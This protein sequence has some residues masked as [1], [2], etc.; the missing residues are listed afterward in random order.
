MRDHGYTEQQIDAGGLRITTTVNK[1]Y[2][3]AAVASGQRRDGRART[4][5]TLREALV[6]DRPEDRRGASPTTAGRAAPTYDYAQAQRQPGSSMKPYVLATALEQGIGVQARRDGSSPQTFPDRDGRRSCNS[7]GASCPACTLQEAITR[8]LNTTFYGLAYE[9]GPGERPR[10][11]A[12][13]HRPARDLGDR[14]QPGRQARRWPTRRAAAPARR[15][16]S[17]STR[18]ARSTRR[19]G[20]P[21]SPAGGVH[22]DPYFVAKVDRLRGHRAARTRRRRGRAGDPGRR[23]Q[24]RHLR[25]SRA[26]PQYSRRALDGGREVASKTGTAGPRPGEQLRRLDGR[27][28][29]VDLDGGLDG[30]RRPSSRSSTPTAGSSTGPAC[31]ARSGSGS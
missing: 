3:D 7:G 19:S 24:R 15:S 17:G 29:A 23:R 27:L 31:R 4:A 28:H 20:S 8:S 26:S 1:G 11:S 21:R 6:V 13:G 16:A 2:Q 22:R 9:V 12:R 30:H 25:A 5:T 10:R 18:C 14:R